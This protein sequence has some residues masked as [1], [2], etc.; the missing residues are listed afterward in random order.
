VKARPK[1]WLSLALTL[2]GST[3]VI[4]AIATALNFT[5][6]CAATVTDCGA[7]QRRMSFVVVGLGV[8]WLGYLV[9]KFI[10]SPNRFR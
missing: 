9:V 5:G 10:R 1:N 3:I 6:D 4:V 7:P 8:V 2:V